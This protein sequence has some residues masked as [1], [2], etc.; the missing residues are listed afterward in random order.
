M[1]DSPPPRR[2]PPPLTRPKGSTPSRPADSRTSTPTPSL[3]PTTNEV[4]FGE[5][6]A[7]VGRKEKHYESDDASRHDYRYRTAIDP[8]RRMVVGAV[9]G[10]RAAG[11][12]AAVVR[13]VRRRAG[14]RVMR[15]ITLT[16][17]RP[18]S[19]RSERPTARGWC[20]PAPADRAGPVT[21]TSNYRRELTSATV[22]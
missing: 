14:R 6:L 7:F 11:A 17:P 4:Q 3:P 16:S 15:L 21:P 2:T 5:T 22:H 20:R 10:E 8:E 9:V 18:T 12:A 13:D 19:E 1:P